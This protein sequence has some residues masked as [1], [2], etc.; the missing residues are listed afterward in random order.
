MEGVPARV[1]RLFLIKNLELRISVEAINFVSLL[2]AIT[3]AD[4]QKREIHP[5]KRA[6]AVD[7]LFCSPTF[8]GHKRLKWIKLN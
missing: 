5:S 3:A 6:L 4:L 8:G 1:P 7:F 2:V